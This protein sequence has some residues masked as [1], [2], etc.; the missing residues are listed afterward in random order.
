MLSFGASRDV[1]YREKTL[2]SKAKELQRINA[3]HGD[4]YYF[5]PSWDA[6]TEHSVPA[7]PHVSEKRVSIVFFVTRPKSGPS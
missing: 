5:A 2:I 3:S 7:M 1:V 6:K 4:L